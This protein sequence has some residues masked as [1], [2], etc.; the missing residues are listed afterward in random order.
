MKALEQNGLSIE[1]V[2][3]LIDIKKGNK[4]AILS[5]MK[6]ANIDP[7]ELDLDAD[8]TEYT[9]GNY[10]PDEYEMKFE[11]VVS[12]IK[13]S[14][15]FDQTVD[16]LLNRWD[17]GSRDFLANEPEILEYVND[18]LQPDE[19]GVVVYDLVAPVAEKNK[20]LDGGR[21]S[22]FEYYV[23]ARRGFVEELERLAAS[24][25][26]PMQQQAVQQANTGSNRAEQNRAAQRNV[27]APT[28][29]KAGTASSA[30]SATFDFSDLSDE[31]LDQLLE[32][33]V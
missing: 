23:E 5:I 21:K 2:N 9:P 15:T 26:E 19:A 4:D 20:L 28:R 14:P 30:G 10:A 24:A 1:D 17:D 16:I 3:L 7:L 31:E 8:K 6:E 18:D 29:T 25:Q 13:D 12:N 27:V 32:E 11:D 33:T 22:D